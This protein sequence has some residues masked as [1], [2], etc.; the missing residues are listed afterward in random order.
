[1]PKPLLAC[2]LNLPRPS[3]Q[4]KP[5]RP[6]QSNQNQSQRK[7]NQMDFDNNILWSTRT[8][9]PSRTRRVSFDNGEVLDELQVYGSYIYVAKGDITTE[10][11]DV[12]VNA[13]NEYLAHGGGV[14]GAISRKGGPELQKGSNEIV[15]KYG[16]I[17]TGSAVEQFAPASL[18]CRYVIHAIGPVYHNGKE[19][20]EGLLSNC[21]EKTLEIADRLS[22]PVSSLSFPAISSG[23]FGFPKDLCAQVFF[24]TILLY[25]KEHPK[26][27]IKHIRLTN[28]DWPTVE[29]F[30][31]AMVNIKE[32]LHLQ[33]QQE[34]AKGKGEQEKNKENV[35]KGDGEKIEEEDTEKNKKQ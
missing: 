32:V 19:N 11:T 9:A 5:F 22:P 26:T 31:E 33:E 27:N 29:V 18:K 30:Q 12:I 20:E 16:P 8:F 6:P 1:M 2:L 17:P 35:K 21:I 3:N 13:A 24:T 15:K 7:K 14:A 25:L 10:D 23:I 4:P 34:K 28:F